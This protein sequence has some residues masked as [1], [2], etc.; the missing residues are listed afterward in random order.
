MQNGLID[1]LHIITFK[2]LD[3]IQ[4]LPVLCPK[5]LTHL[6]NTGAMIITGSAHPPST[7][8]RVLRHMKSCKVRETLF[9]SEWNG[10]EWPSAIFWPLLSDKYKKFASF[11]EEVSVLPK[12]K[13]LI[14][15][16]PGPKEVYLLL[17]LVALHS[18]FWQ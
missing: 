5:L 10:T 6:C 11:I 4:G 15:E 7:I 1:S 2:C 14:I 16:G 3:L 9:V 13:D 17:F 12:I 8:P 18:T